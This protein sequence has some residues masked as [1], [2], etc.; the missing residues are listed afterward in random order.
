MQLSLEGRA[1]IVTDAEGERKQWSTWPYAVWS[2]L[3]EEGDENIFGPTNLYLKHLDENKIKALEKFYEKCFLAIAEEDPEEIIRQVNLEVCALGRALD[4][5][6][7]NDWAREYAEIPLD[8]SS[9]IQH[10]N[11]FA[12]E[13]TYLQSEC[14]ELGAY[15]ILLKLLMPVIGYVCQ[16]ISSY[17]GNEHKELKAMQIFDNSRFSN[18]IAHQ[19][20]I[21]YCNKLAKSRSS[22]I[23]LALSNNCSVLDLPSY[24]LAFCIVRR[25]LRA[26]LRNKDEGLL[27]YIYKFLEGNITQKKKDAL[28]DKGIAASGE[29]DGDSAYEHFR[30][31]EKIPR[32]F[33][34]ECSVYLENTRRVARKIQPD[35]LLI[36]DKAM[37]YYDAMM[38][39]KYFTIRESFIPIMALALRSQMAPIMFK[40]IYM[41]AA[42]S[43]LA[44]VAA[45]CFYNEMEDIAA[46]LTSVSHQNDI[47]TIKKN[48]LI[49]KLDEV[50]KKSVTARYPYV[51]EKRA[52]GNTHPAM[53][54][55]DRLAIIANTH[56][57]EHAVDITNLRY[58]LAN[59]ILK[60]PRVKQLPR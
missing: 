26:N 36:E 5:P 47:N 22:S 37:E 54:F 15:G 8:P 30:V 29:S 39:N 35:N 60:T 42:I 51:P 32:E 33:I 59:F 14:F 52:T 18:M 50:T 43:S 27:S 9:P 28:N 20:L 57:F 21:I 3:V 49:R 13:T 34:V 11:G 41:Q 12:V 56:T 40:V 58:S 24:L 45:W 19:R 2:K 16:E 44:A 55:I 23:S 10:N 4:V 1:I 31:P 25:I 38:G 48:V 17:T 46:I 53:Q 6:G 7:I